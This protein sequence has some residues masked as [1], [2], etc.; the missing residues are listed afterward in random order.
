MAKE[1][2]IATY[3][4]IIKQAQE[5][6][7][8]P[9]YLLQGDEDYYIDKAAQTLLDHALRPE[10][11]DFNLDIVY[12]SDTRANDIIN[13]ARQYPMMADRRV[14]MVREFQSLNGKETLSSYIKNPMGST[15]LILCHKHGMLDGRKGLAGDIKK[16]GTVMESKRLYDNQLPAFVMGYVTQMQ[17][18][19]EQQAIQ[20][21]CEHVGSD[22]TRMASEID[23][24]KLALGGAKQITASLV[25]EQTGVSKDYNI[26]ELQNALSRKD[27]V[28]ANK[29][30]NYFDTNPKSFALQPVLSGLF[31][32]FTDVMTA[33]YAPDKSENG[34]AQWLGKNPFVARQALIPASRNYTARKVMN[35]LTQIRETDARSKGIGGEKTPPGDLLRELIFVI[36][37]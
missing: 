19:I 16:H 28:K 12:G 30:V 35:I 6:R 34:V 8:A 22:L 36:L 21:L 26:F 32:F 23:K 17:L 3:A 1:T 14:V 31:G 11:R 33:Y 4:E 15:M 13:M 5:Q 27:V 18:G 9:V 20:M 7:F 24:L 37:H 25:E 29:I 2:G 10:E